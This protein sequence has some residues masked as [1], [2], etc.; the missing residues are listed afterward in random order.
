[1]TTI[2]VIDESTLV[3]VTGTKGPQGPRG[4][5]GPAWPATGVQEASEAARD[6]AQAAANTAAS[7]AASALQ[8]KQEANSSA[9]TAGVAAST[10]QSAASTAV[11]SAAVA[12]TKADVAT[13]AAT[14]AQQQADISTQ[15]AL[16][17]KNYSNLAVSA[18]TSATGAATDA[19]NAL[20]GVNAVFDNFDDRYL[21]AKESDPVRDNDGNPIL[22]GALYYNSITGE[23][24]FYSGT[25]WEAPTTSSISAATTATNQAAIATSKAAEASGYAAEAL[26]SKNS[27]ALNAQLTSSYA[28]QA[29]GF[30]DLAAGSASSAAASALDATAKATNASASAQTATTAAANASTSAAFSD[31]RASASAASAASAGTYAEAAAVSAANAGNAATRADTSSASASGSA[32]QALALYGGLSA[33]QA[34]VQQ[35]ATQASVAS[36]YATAASSVMQ[37][38]LSGVTATALHRS[39]NAITSMFVYDTSKDSDGGAWT[40]KCQGTS[41]YNETTYGSWLTSKSDAG[42]QSELD[43]R[44]TGATLGPELFTNPS[45]SAG[46]ITYSGGVATF[47]NAISG[48][49]INQ[50]VLTVGKIYEATFRVVSISQGSIR[51]AAGSVYAPITATS[52]GTYTTHV[53]ATTTGSASVVANGTTTAVVD[54]ISFKEVASLTTKSG[55]YFQLATDGKFYR[56]WKNLLSNPLDISQSTWNKFNCTP[57][58]NALANPINGLVNAPLFVDNT[59]S[60]SHGIYAAP[61]IT[62]GPAVGSVYVKAYGNLQRIALGL[63]NA[64]LAYA[65]FDINGVTAGTSTGSAGTS[66]VS[67]LISITSVGNGW[68]RISNGYSGVGSGRIAIYACQGATNTIGY[69]GDGLSGFYAYAPQYELGSTLTEPE[70]NKDGAG[71]SEVFRG[72]KREFPKLSA[73]VAE[74]GSVTIYDLTESGRPMWMRFLTGY[75]NNYLNLRLLGYQTG[76]SCLSVLNGVLVAG[77]SLGSSHNDAISLINFPK[78]N[79]VIIGPTTTALGTGKFVTGIANRNNTSQQNTV[80]PNDY[81]VTGNDIS[82]VSMTVLPDAPIDINTGLKTPT[83]ALA[84]NFTS[85]GRITVIK[86]DNT[87]VTS[88]SNAGFNKVSITPTLLSAGRQDNSWYYTYNPSSLGSNFTLTTIASAASPDWAT[89]NNSAIINGTRSDMARFTYTGTSNIFTKL[90]NFES[91][92]SKSL[93]AKIAPAYNTGYLVGDIRR[94]YLAETVVGNTDTTEL[95]TNG[96][97]NV[98]T[99]GW[100]QYVGTISVVGGRLRTTA[101]GTNVGRAIQTISCV[102]GKTYKISY[103]KYKGTDTSSGVYIGIV[104]STVSGAIAYATG[105]TDGAG[106]LIFTATQS[107]H[108]IH[109]S[110]NTATAGVYS[111]FDNISVKE[112]VGDRSYKASSATINGTLTKSQVAINTQLVGCSGFSSTNYAQEPYSAD[113]DFGTGEFS[114]S[115][116]SNILAS[117]A[118]AG[119]IVHRGYSTGPYITLGIDTTSKLVAAVFDGTT[120]RTV[121]STL[122]YNISTWIKVR[123]VY[124]TDGT[125]SL[126]VNG[127]VVAN[128]YGTPL[129]TLNNS[130]AV[131]TIGNTYTLD[132]PF[133]GSIALLK[134]SAT[135]PTQEQSS[136]AYEQEKQMFRDGTQVC[137][138]DTNPVLDMAYD[139]AK[140][141]WVVVSS[142]SESEWSG[143][144]RTAVTTVPAGNYTKVATTSGVKLEARST[145]NPGVDITIPPYLLRTELV[146]R[147]EAAARLT[148]S[149]QTFDYVGGFTATTTTGSTAVTSASGI[150][151]PGSYIG[152]Q[153]TGTGVQ[154]GTIVSTI[155]GTTLYLSKPATASGTNVQLSFTD[156][157]LPTGYEAKQVFSAGAQKQE[158]TTKDYTRIFDGFKETIR[159]G[160]APGYQAWVSIQAARSIA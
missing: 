62:N 79:G 47:T 26:S 15:Q 85:A 130:N 78:D 53:I 143:L 158:G 46:S 50:T 145:G 131:L 84:S 68:Y 120:L 57:T 7:E 126:L 64:A 149:L 110:T 55:D 22:V 147:A 146:R 23:V 115:A 157:V 86:H 5:E 135:V 91:T 114:I 36:G 124:T 17:A 49:N 21:G 2:N 74:S 77:R 18:A 73:I 153:V 155:S 20:V 144:V 118:V 127:Q 148:N 82:G 122:Q 83:I 156:F 29:S 32:S 119:T 133:P 10:A 35:A 100:T 58:Y 99:T 59:T 102:V 38:D 139:D 1:M 141:R 136:W 44:C 134:F 12:S 37:Q 71:T 70:I 109:L 105:T 142:T 151:Y 140:A 42:F 66:E 92:P 33:V 72:N 150:S 107:T 40:D 13:T 113:L 125:L 108:Y 121:T 14:T 138:P 63:E 4:F 67:S 152:A 48:V 160:V 117:N 6:A 97:F 19:Q 30:K 61:S 89:G 128:T 45:P 65:Y 101:D 93:S 88:S 24:K 87:T 116:W 16:Q 132:A 9:G 154:A 112:V 11:S 98:D 94:A 103:E 43:A 39:P 56:L 76:I 159:F 25:R 8:S 137:L 27:A 34:A 90:K 111:E 95:V 51:V 69:T 104:A 75:A 81:A 60:G 41:W 31:T 123:V 129:L 96:T 52:A 80:L 3:V 106:S 28:N 54:S